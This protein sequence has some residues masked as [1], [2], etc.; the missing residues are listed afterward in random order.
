MFLDPPKRS[1]SCPV[2][3][4]TEHITELKCPEHH[5]TVLCIYFIRKVLKLW[6]FL[7]QNKFKTHLTACLKSLQ[8]K[9]E[10]YLKPKRASIMERFCEF[11]TAHRCSTGLKIVLWKYWIF[12]NEAYLEQIIV[13]ATT[14]SVSC[15]NFNQFIIIHYGS[16]L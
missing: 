12:Q 11:L 16:C 14:R 7:K 2:V 9:A 15:F 8:V 6:R 10:T 1:D 5:I 13:I 3:L 4:I